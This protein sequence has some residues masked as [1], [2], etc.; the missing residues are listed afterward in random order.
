MRSNSLHS[1]AMFSL[2]ATSY[3]PLFVLIIFKQVYYSW[4]KIWS[5]H[6]LG[7]NEIGSD[8]GLSI[9]LGMLVV[10]GLFGYFLTLTNVKRNSGNG[11]L[12]KIGELENK[13]SDTIGYI[14]TY[15][16]PFLYDDFSDWYKALSFLFVLLV[17]YRIYI[18]SNLLMNNPF[19][20]FRYSTYA[21]SCSPLGGGI[22]FTGLLLSTNHELQEGAIV[23]LYPIGNKVFIQDQKV[24]CEHDA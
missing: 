4:D 7:W 17:I 18:R 2:F 12:V 23:K 22:H 14:A 13:N 8:F 20:G 5:I 6:S 24:R 11:Q 16:I 9:F 1:I 15:I 3:L 10:F 21:F 19:M